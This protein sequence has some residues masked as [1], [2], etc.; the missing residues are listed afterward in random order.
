MRASRRYTFALVSIF[1]F[2]LAS[3]SVAND[4]SHTLRTLR[5]GKEIFRFDT[6][7][8]EAFWGDALGLHE[9]IEGAA[10]GGVGDGLTPRRALELG[11]KVDADALPFGVRGALRRGKVDLDDPAV[12][13]MLLRRDAIVGLTGF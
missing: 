6:F 7:G 9:A 12:T 3:V 5:D 13:L 4:R 8:D 11:L 10:N 1:A 2:S